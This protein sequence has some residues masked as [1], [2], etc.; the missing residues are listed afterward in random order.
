[1]SFPQSLGGNPDTLFFGITLAVASFLL[2]SSVSVYALDNPTSTSLDNLEA[3]LNERE[4]ALYYLETELTD[5]KTDKGAAALYEDII[6]CK[7]NIVNDAALTPQQK[8][9]LLKP[10]IKSLINLG[11]HE[12]ALT[13]CRDFFSQ[14]PKNRQEAAVLFCL[15]GT[16]FQG[17]E[18]YDLAIDAFKQAQ[19]AILEDPK[20]FFLPPAEVY[21]DLGWCYYKK[22][23][24][25][26][27]ITEY[28]HCL[29]QNKSLDTNSLQ[30]TL[31]QIGRCHFFLKDYSQ[32]KSSFLKAV[33]VAKD[34]DLAQQAKANIEDMEKINV[35]P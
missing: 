10:M 23:D 26:N 29:Q 25:K 8:V 14:Q 12:E 27:A 15:A 6:S 4:A 5:R 17:L 3:H 9:V 20:G 28:N 2:F 13:L 11:R 35:K 21:L 7:D 18:R 22:A 1:M 33:D 16:G 19:Q 31:L 32:A 34:T 24:Y 30:W